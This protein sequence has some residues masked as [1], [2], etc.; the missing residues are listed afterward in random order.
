M[1]AALV[2][3]RFRGPAP[4]GALSTAAWIALYVGQALWWLWLARWGGARSVQGWRAAWLLDPVAW[5]WDAEV[6]KLFA[7]LS[8]VGSTFWFILGLVEP[9]ARLFYP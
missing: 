5:R 3:V 7:W 4:R 9:A 8:L 1:R 6:I 2:V